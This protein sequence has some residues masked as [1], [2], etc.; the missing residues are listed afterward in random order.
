VSDYDLEVAKKKFIDGM[1]LAE[2]TKKLINFS[3]T[4][5]LKL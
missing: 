4:R 2:A 1:T 3:K 5:K